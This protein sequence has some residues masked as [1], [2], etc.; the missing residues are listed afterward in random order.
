MF[1]AFFCY[2]N[3]LC[4][5][6][7]IHSRQQSTWPHPLAANLTTA[8]AFSTR[9]AAALNLSG[10]GFSPGEIT[11]P[12]IAGVLK[13]SHSALENNLHVEVQNWLSGITS[14]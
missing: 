1:Q 8:G 11:Q 6:I 2:H 4:R 5:S 3:I 7:D 10:S 13:G 9:R 12:V 14:W